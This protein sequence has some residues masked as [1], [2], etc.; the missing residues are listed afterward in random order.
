MNLHSTI[1][2]GRSWVEE[3]E[4]NEEPSELDLDKWEMN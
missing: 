1:V 4:E 2:A 3:G